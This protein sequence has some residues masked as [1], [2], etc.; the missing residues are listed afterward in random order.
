MRTIVV[1][2]ALTVAI[3]SSPVATAE[4]ATPYLPAPTGR[5]PVGTTSLYLKD[6][7]RP[8]TW[9]PSVPYRELMVSLFYPTSSS[10]GPK[11]QY[12]T[13]QESVANLER[14]N[15]PGLAL[16]VFS[17][18]R[19]N[20][21]VDAR[22]TGGRHDLPLVVLSPGY[23]Q[24]RA[25]LSMWAE[26]L[27]SHGYVVAVIDHT[28][29]NR[30]TT[31]P[32]GHVTSC[33]AC[34]LDG[35]D[36]PE[37]DAKLA[38]GRALDTSFVLD[39]LVGR[40]PAWRYANLIDPSRIGMTGH[41]A[42]GSSTIQAMLADQRIRAGANVD[43]SNHVPIPDSGLA[44]PFMFM[45]ETD[46]YVPGQPGPYDDWETDWQH[47]TGWK[48][49]LMVTG[50]VHQSFTDLGVLA[51]QLGVDLGGTIDPNR[52]MDLTRTYLRAFFDQHLLGRAQPL[53]DQP[54]ARYPEV[55]LARTSTPF[56]PAPTGDKPVG[57]LPVYLKDT[58]RPDP[59]VPSVPYRE[60]MLSLFYPAASSRGGKATYMT[61]EESTALLTDS[62]IEPLDLLSTTR[63]NSVAYARPA[64]H[65]LP[66]I[67]LSPGYTKPRATLTALAEDLASHG[68][69]VALVD[70]TYEN[71]ATTFPDGRVVG[72]ASCDQP[73]D[74]AF[75]QKL[76]LGRAADVSFVLDELT[77]GKW[78]G[79]V[80]PSRIGMAGHSVGGAST[81]PAM[82][83]DDRI[84]AGMNIDGSTEF[85]IPYP[86]LSRPFMFVSHERVP[87]ATCA[88][89]NESWERD[90]PRMTGW[91][92]WAE[93][94]GT[95]HASFTDV[96]LFADE[97]GVDIGATTGG[98]RTLVITRAY[99]NAFFDQHLR[100]RPSELLDQPGYPEVAF[101]HRP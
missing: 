36:H 61:P 8:D 75:W 1:A 47:L 53:L 62:G 46:E 88:P 57:S 31:F 2:T 22:P 32:D 64:G 82:V 95:Q 27:A 39:E 43:G 69:V 44:R 84:R 7:S 12:M 66:M 86:G 58:S 55:S 68:Y 93:V 10:H 13:P 83:G 60:L 30:A 90:W 16:D 91:K 24:P 71:A 80:D 78:A 38:A 6:T 9:V 34:D 52:G 67:V 25:T 42:G 29:E 87:D 14:Q 70:H 92:R 96:G 41:S 18:V 20:A 37:F 3:A 15:I 19:T 33:A 5:Q 63:T 89:G 49:W 17:T 85:E 54:S 59:W 35:P 76:E 100:G 97:W 51:G 74:P 21:V 94:A 79:L 73:H 98:L 99:V 26:D 101:C 65:H 11:R 56:L 50:M 45:G 23:T 28:Y 40:H 81:I 4:P 72:C 48:R 77:R